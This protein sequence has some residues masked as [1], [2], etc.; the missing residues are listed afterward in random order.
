MIRT[1]LSALLSFTIFAT[2]SVNAAALREGSSDATV[3]ASVSSRPI[4]VGILR[5]G[6]PYFYI[7][8]FG[9][10]MATLRRTFKYQSVTSREFGSVSELAAAI[11][12]REIDYLITSSGFHAYASR[13]LGTTA[14]ATQT[15][16]EAQSP[17]AST[18]AVFV[19]KTGNSSIQALPDLKGKTLAAY[20]PE[21]FE[22][23]Y[24]ALGELARAGVTPDEAKKTA[25]FTNYV[26]PDVA[27]S[28]LTGAADAGILPVC[29]LEHLIANGDVA[30]DALR[31]IGE[32]PSDSGLPCRRSTDLYPDTVFSA[33]PDSDLRLSNAVAAAL[34]TA[35]VTRDG[36]GW[37]T[38]ND[39]SRVETLYEE[40]GIPPFRREFSWASLWNHYQKELGAAAVLLLL[41]LLHVLRSDYLVRVRTRD[42]QA[43][44]RKREESERAAKDAEDRLNQAERAETVSQMSAMIAHELNQPIESVINYAAGLGR[45]L[46]RKSESDAV[47]RRTLNEIV[48]GSKRISDIVDRVRAHARQEKPEKERTRMASFLET[49][50][51]HF[52]RTKAGAGVRWVK[53]IDCGSAE[54]LIDPLETELLLHNLFKNAAEAVSEQD[55]KVITVSAALESPSTLLVTVTDNGPAVDQTLIDTLSKP[56]SSGK[57]SGLGLGLFISRSIAESHGGRL[58]F[59]RSDTGSVTAALRLSVI[60]IPLKN[61]D[62]A[63]H[64]ET[65]T[66]KETPSC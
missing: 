53:A 17:N 48:K 37:S 33:V 7:R 2:G 49:A 41:L 23:W 9:P 66:R 19:V 61:T 6:S 40:L 5:S 57:A 34:L 28:V 11:R 15:R 25:L 24:A 3:T 30:R 63:N 38:A 12:S 45:Y 22:G 47:I 21:D 55:E 58:T 60:E 42:L 26:F 50:I 64:Q 56:L 51:D 52:S 16:A 36:Y 10:T 32:K 59:S 65:Q 4:R 54:S 62:A 46:D 43:E 20:S 39:F 8:T 31:V 27:A 1:A 29:E 14:L 35:P 13:L 44:T 18:G